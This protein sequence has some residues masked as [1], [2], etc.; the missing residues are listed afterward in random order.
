MPWAP[1]YVTLEELREYVRIH[2]E[3]DDVDDE[4]ILDA[5]AGASRAIDQECL[6]QFG[7]TDASEARYYRA[8]YSK[9]RTGWLVATDDIPSAVGLQVHLDT[10]G[11]ASY[12]TE[13][14]GYVLRPTN[15]PSRGKPWEG[16]LIGLPRPYQVTG[17]VNEVRVTAPV[18]GWASQPRTI[19][20]AAKM[21]G[22]RF[23]AR[24]DAPFGVAG[25]PEQG[26]ELRL[27]AR[28]DPDVAVMLN[29]YRRRV[30]MR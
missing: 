11:D 9:T 7:K 21:Q 5:A 12:A 29:G 17:A 8:R 30:R 28:V 1:D 4:E 24:R 20:L 6:R 16:L 2:G 26:S 14:T 10:A 25:N 22:S 23:L 13:V 3:A 18:F 27:L 15:A 19:T